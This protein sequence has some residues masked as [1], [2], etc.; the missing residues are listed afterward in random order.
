[1]KDAAVVGITAGASAPEA[2]VDDVIVALRKLG[3]VQVSVV[4]GIEE[5]VEFRLPAELLRARAT[6]HGVS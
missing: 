4:P 5:K 3:P 1:M 2:L 6:A